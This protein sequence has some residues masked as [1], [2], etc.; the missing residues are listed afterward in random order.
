[1]VSA[2]VKLSARAQ[3]M[4]ELRLDQVMSRRWRIVLCFFLRRLQMWQ[5][6]QVFSGRRG[7]RCTLVGR[8]DVVVYSEHVEWVI[9]LLDRG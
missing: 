3:Q 2:A 5:C 4:A 6:C 7:I 1:M 8:C 9:G